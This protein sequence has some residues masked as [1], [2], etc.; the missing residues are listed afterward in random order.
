LAVGDEAFQRKCDNFF[1]EIKEDPSKTVILVTHSMDA[2]K[3]YCN[4]AIL[5]Q[6]GKIVVSGNT[7]DVA[8]RYTLENLKERD[9][10]GQHKG[11]EFPTGLNKTVPL[12]FASPTDSP[13]CNYS[14]D[15]AFEVEYEY[16]GNGP[17]YMALALHDIKRGGVPYGDSFDLT[18]RGHHT[19][20]FSIPTTMFNN[21]D[22]RIVASIHE[23][24]GHDIDAALLVAFTNE[25][26]ACDF[27][28]RDPNGKDNFA[29]I[30]KNS[31]S[32]EVVDNELAQRQRFC[33]GD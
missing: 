32:Y 16:N 20:H 9:E 21:G 6:D 26:N 12:L 30:N 23:W 17:F 24:D 10:P 5:I 19:V 1:A 13:M 22:Y 25:S 29:L 18:A 8:D 7:D 14:T 2:V 28:L 11:A 33:I 4:D 31:L 3:R 15:F 27:S